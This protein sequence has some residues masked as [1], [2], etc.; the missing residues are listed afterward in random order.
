MTLIGAALTLLMVA[1]VMASRPFAAPDEASHYLRALSIANG[2]LL[3]P[4]VPYRLPGLSVA[5]QAWTNHDTRAVAVPARL[6]PPD[7]TCMNG[8]PD[9][10]TGGCTEATSTGD[11]HP[12]PY[13]LPALALTVSHNAS[14]G[15]W[16]SRLAS[17]LPCVAL[18]ILAFALLWS[19][20]G[21]SLL[22][23]LL[24][25]TP[26]V[27]FV[28][29]VINPNG[30]EIAAALAFAAAI[31]RISR[32]PGRPP[33][34]VWGGLVVSGAVAILAWQVGPLFV[35][36]DI[37]LGIALL[38]RPGL[39]KVR[40][41]SR[42]LRLSAL[43]LGFATALYLSYGMSSGVFHSTFGI[44]PIRQSLRQGFDQ[45]GPVLQH[46]V[47][48]FG[49]LN[50]PLPSAA[51]WLWWGM[52]LA[53]VAAGLYVSGSRERWLLLAVTV[54]A[55]VFPVLFYAW[56]YRFTGFGLQGRYVL[57][58][59]ILVPL[60]AGEFI[61]QCVRARQPRRMWQSVL[62]A[63]IGIVAVFQG[64]AWW[65]NAR[66]SAGAPHTIRFYAHAL[67]KPPLGWGLWIALALLGMLTLLGVGLA[68]GFRG[69][70]SDK[71]T[72]FSPRRT[73]P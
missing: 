14:T 41:A 26:M 48:S 2:K 55:L 69:E 34:W 11:Y 6:S 4:K 22:G 52:V 70:P 62:G 36:A 21:W 9:I 31:L 42:P 59:L 28:G 43:G 7:V 33:R 40:S 8:K 18:I 73:C 51:Y 25:T 66:Y 65:I 12:L 27:L 46:A 32:E 53:L 1:W 13:V 56:V 16:L 60:V 10:G 29:S 44:S 23:P 63:V 68:Q 5:T 38:G 58:V 54:L 67:W 57:P 3:G 39:R 19:G 71:R 50:V 15:L 45:L 49:S 64:Y 37:A 72:A 24:A 20:N 17:A 30:L 47:G 35:I 61:H